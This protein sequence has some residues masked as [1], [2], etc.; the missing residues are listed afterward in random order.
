M[1]IY[2][3]AVYGAVEI[4]DCLPGNP[5][6]AVVDFARVSL[7]VLNGF[8]QL[9]CPVLVILWRELACHTASVRQHRFS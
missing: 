5:E 7:I 2:I 9:C 8:L 6:N 3:P 1:Y 4:Q